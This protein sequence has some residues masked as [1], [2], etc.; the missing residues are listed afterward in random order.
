MVREKALKNGVRLELRSDPSV[1][2]IEGDERRVRQ[3]VFNLLSNAVKF[4]PEG[5]PVEVGTARG[6]HQVTVWVR[7]TGPG[8]DL[9]DQELIFEEFRQARVVE[10]ERPEGTGLG[11]ALSRRLDRVARRPHLGRERA[12]QREHL[13]LHPS[14][15]VVVDGGQAR[16]RR[17][18]Q[19]DQHGAR[20]RRAACEGL[21]RSRSV[22]RGRGASSSRFA[23]HPD[24]ILLD[25]QLP[26]IDGVTTLA[27]APRE[28]RNSEDDRRG[29][30]GAGDGRRPRILPRGGLRRLHLEA[31]RRSGVH[32]RSRALL[33]WLATAP[34]ASSSSTTCRRTSSCWRPCSSPGATRS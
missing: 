13:P 2:V 25:I 18:G 31:D 22:E 8:I 27:E 17:R 11:L 24:L 29:A 23:A 20:S 4:T 33:R 12:G 32:R 15:R 6:E 26:G 5:G 7:D 19:R 14:P 16:P 3:V 30:D 21:P 9:D 34:D 1:D 28:R 10:G